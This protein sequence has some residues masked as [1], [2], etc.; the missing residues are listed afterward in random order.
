MENS[1]SSALRAIA[2]SLR[3]PVI[4]ILLLLAATAL[5]LTGSL[6][7]EYFT[8]RRRLR[9]KMPA[10]IR[11]LHSAEDLSATIAASGLLRRQ[12]LV[13]MEVCRNMELPAS[14]RAALAERLL[15]QEQECYNRRIRLSDMIARLGPMFGLLGTLIPLGPG[16]IALGQGDTYTLSQSLLTAFDTTILGMITAAFAIVISAIRKYWYSQQMSMLRALMECVLEEMEL[17]S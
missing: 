11:A 16:I 6:I 5:V 10:L 7:A 12:K 14:S 17:R 4:I 8:A 3:Y 2:S 15:E 9:V 13:L 1:L